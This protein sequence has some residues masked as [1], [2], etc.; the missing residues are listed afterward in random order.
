MSVTISNKEKVFLHYYD[1]EPTSGNG[2]DMKE[3]ETL[4]RMKISRRDRYGMKLQPYHFDSWMLALTVATEEVAALPIEITF[5]LGVCG[6]GRFVS[7]A[8]KQLWTS[9]VEN[10]TRE[11]AISLRYEKLFGYCPLCSSLCHKEEKCPLLRSVAEKKREGREGNG[12]WYD[13]GKHDDR[14]SSYK[15]VVINGNQ[16]QQHKERDGRDYYGKGK[17]KMVEEADSKWVKV[18]DRGNKGPFTNHGSFRGGEMVLDIDL[19]KRRTRL[20]VEAGRK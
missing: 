14:A 11:E 6:G 10:F 13:G 20:R 3:G 1:A 5:G 2:G 15:G 19:P 12:G 9:R 4:K 16:N 17:G 18:A 8:L 7:F